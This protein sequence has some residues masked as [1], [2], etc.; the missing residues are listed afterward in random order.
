MLSGTT[1]EAWLRV[2]PCHGWQGLQPWQGGIYQEGVPGFR[3]ETPGS[4]DKACLPASLL[5]EGLPTDRADKPEWLFGATTKAVQQSAPSV[6]LFQPCIDA[7]SLESWW[8][9]P[10]PSGCMLL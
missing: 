9:G 1:V 7:H 2:A 4:D 8:V 5:A 6:A 10:R 3:G